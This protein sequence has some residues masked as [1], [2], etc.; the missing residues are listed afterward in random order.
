MPERSN[1]PAATREPASPARSPAAT[2]THR[3]SWLRAHFP[4]FRFRNYRL[5]WG[6]QLIS[7]TGRWMQTVA[8][9]WLV[10]DVL[11]ATAFQLSLVTGL[12]FAPILLFGLFAGVI[13]DRVPKRS[14]LLA[15][16]IVMAVF[17]GILAVLVVTDTVQLWHVFVVA[18]G[19]GIANAFDMP[20][21]QAFVSEM[22]DRDAVMNAVALNSAVFN[23]GRIVGPAIAGIL[24]AAV[25]PAICFTLNAIS[26]LA[27]IYA[28]LQMR[29]RFVPKA[30][31]GSPIAGLREG[32]R[33]V[34]AT[35]NI[36]RPILLVGLIGIFGMNFNVW[37]PLLTTENYAAGATT[38]GLLFAAMGVG[39]LTGALGLAAFG[40][41]PNR[42]RM[43]LTAL[44]IGIALLLLAL[45]A[46]ISFGIGLAMVCLA[47]A[48]F[49]NTT[50]T[51]TANTL[52]QTAASDELRGRV[53]S[54]YSTVFAGT[55][56]IGALIAGA[57]ADLGGAPASVAFGGLIVVVGV[58]ILATQARRTVSTA[59][60][61]VKDMSGAS[62]GSTNASQLTTTPLRN[63]H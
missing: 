27:V 59:S 46:T 53:M 8:Q 58:L 18:L 54:V 33:Y 15:T 47:A 13:A 25:G 40:R 6:G 50:T 43:Y 9:A 32:L 38:F 55:I 19:T 39:A 31:T 2:T 3:E 14:L 10:V 30:A 34:R 21:R 16:Q 5:F 7:I 60:P 57:I 29:V 51:A 20:A 4:A 41:S 36:L 62:A 12:Q 49:A 37:L 24:L 44:S 35:P 63:K 52:V 48:G 26:Y 45:S 23:S 1:A 56:P 28:L 11:D 17:A 61:R 42:G 22:V